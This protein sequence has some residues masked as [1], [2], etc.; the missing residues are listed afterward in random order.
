MKTRSI[1][2]TVTLCVF[3]LAPAGNA[4]FFFPFPGPIPAGNWAVNAYGAPTTLTPIGPGAPGGNT[5]PSQLTIQPLAN[6]NVSLSL[7]YNRVVVN[8]APPP[9]AVL[10]VTVGDPSAP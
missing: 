6:G 3:A 2:A 9:S 4:Q 1:A 7:E 8:P 5:I 10:A